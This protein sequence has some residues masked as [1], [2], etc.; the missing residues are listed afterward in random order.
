MP[1]AHP[2]PDKPNA[3]LHAIGLDADA[4][5]GEIRALRRL[6]DDIAGRLIASRVFATW[7]PACYGG[8]GGS[9]MDLFDAVEQLAWHHASV[10]WCAMIGGTTALSSGFLSPAWAREI[11]GDPRTMSG[12]F[13][14]PAG[15]ARPVAGG[16]QV[17]GRWSWGSGLSH[18]NWVVGGVLVSDDGQG[19]ATRSDGLKTPIV[20]FPRAEVQLHDNWHTLGLQGTGSV[21]YEVHEVFVPE[22]RWVAFPMHEPV[23]ADPLYRFS[24]V[25][26]LAAGVAFVAVGL[27]RRAIDE[28]I[29]LATTKV[30]AGGS[31]RLAER[32]LVQSQL[33]EAEAAWLSARGALREAVAAGMHEASAEG[34]I[35]IATR[36]RLRL[37]ALNAVER[38]TRAVDLCF[39]AG[40]GSSIHDGSVLQR[41]FCDM[42]TASQHGINSALFSETLGRIAMGV[43]ADSGLL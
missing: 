23:V 17:N 35:G 3:A 32:A 21:D 41:V 31:R 5:A 30:P 16:L 8:L 37:A 36:R 42:H 26:A 12:G 33:V 18:C 14:G 24:T 29:L 19:S 4:R 43:P 7:V 38:C 27:A 6:P 39:S 40:G 20:F 25:G 10:A 11:Y 1:P 22:G 15:R 9:A 34:R 13:A 2:A 28:L